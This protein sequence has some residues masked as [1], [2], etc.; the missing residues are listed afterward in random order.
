MKQSYIILYMGVMNLQIDDYS[1]I[2]VN[3][4]DFKKL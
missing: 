2:H 3:S 1:E 4:I